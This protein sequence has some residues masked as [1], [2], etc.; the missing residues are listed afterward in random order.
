LVLAVG[1]T[2]ASVSD[3]KGV[4]KLCAKMGSQCKKLRRIWVDG[5]YRG[6]LVT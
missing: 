6:K 2:A 4:R 3:A 1:V 5:T